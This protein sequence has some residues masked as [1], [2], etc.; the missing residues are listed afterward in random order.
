[1]WC[2]PALRSGCEAGWPRRR[3]CGPRLPAA[4]AAAAAA[5]ECAIRH[6]AERQRQPLHPQT[7]ARRG[8]ARVQVTASKAAAEEEEEEEEEDW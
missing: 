1:M 5:N 2:G 4:A 3:A 7:A 8:A 6:G